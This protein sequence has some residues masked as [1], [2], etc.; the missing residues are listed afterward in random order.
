MSKGYFLVLDGCE[1]GGKTTNKAYLVQE[2]ESAG[3]EVVST[4]EPGGTPLAEK[5]RELLLAPNPEPMAVDTELLLMFAARAQHVKQVI[6]PALERGAVVISD[7]F[8]D[9][10]FAY[11]G[12]G[13]GVPW[14]RLELLERFVLGDFKPDLTLLFD[15]PV[16]IGMERVKRRGAL[17][18]FE[19]EQKQFFEDVRK[20]YL[21]RA[22]SD[23]R[24]YWV[25]DASQSLDHVQTEM[26]RAV[27][28]IVRAVKPELFDA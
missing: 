1:G 23:M 13:R 28:K 15:L 5:I 3:L 25:I 19:Q 14:E 11:Q 12:G 21:Q 4:R 6:F 26:R 2:L 9:A 24:R 20:A 7:R 18:R 10:T 16:E 27:I 17:D 8:V 22:V